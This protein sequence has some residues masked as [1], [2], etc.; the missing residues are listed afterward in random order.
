MFSVCIEYNE[1]TCSIPSVAKCI[2]CS[3]SCLSLRTD[4]Q[5]LYLNKDRV[6]KY[7]SILLP[8]FVIVIITRLHH[9]LTNVTISNN[10]NSNWECTYEELID[11]IRVDTILLLLLNRRSVVLIHQIK[12]R[13]IILILKLEW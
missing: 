5:K 9:T 8:P 3:V 4:L 11:R 6:T 12:Q 7:N 13:N 10:V 2:D 1:I